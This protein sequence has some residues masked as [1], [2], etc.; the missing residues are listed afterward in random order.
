MEHSLLDSSVGYLLNRTALNLNNLFARRLK[1]YNITPEQF[2]LITR[3]IEE[4]GISQ[5]ELAL[6]SEKDPPGITRML[7]NMLAKGLITKQHNDRRSLAI[8][9]TEEARAIYKD[10][11][12]IEHQTMKDIINGLT[13]EQV[14]SLKTL[15]SQIKQNIG[16]LV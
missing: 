8:Y 12:I 9:L 14:N 10:L 7:D 4:E 2:V 13:E 1:D 11:L 6:R 16:E 3:L 15:L 5:K